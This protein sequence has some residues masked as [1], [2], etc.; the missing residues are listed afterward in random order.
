MHE[1]AFVLTVAAPTVFM[2][3]LRAYAL[4]QQ[5]QSTGHCKQFELFMDRCRQWNNKY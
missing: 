2:A 5:A 1:D 3:W 4:F